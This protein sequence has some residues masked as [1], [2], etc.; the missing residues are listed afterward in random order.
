MTGHPLDEF[1]PTLENGKFVPI[2]KLTEQEDKSTVMIAG[3]LV[4]VE[5]KFTKKESKP[6]AIVTLEDFTGQLEVMIWSEAYTK[7]QS[8]LVQGAVVSITGRLD[9]RE[10]GP[11]LT[12][13]EVKPVKKPTA[14]QPPLVLTL[15]RRATT[16][17]D[18][19]SIRDAILQNPGRR[20]V[21]L[22]FVG[23]GD[24]PVRLLPSDDFR[25]SPAAEAMLARWVVL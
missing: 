16:E 14:K 18:L 9:L 17:E 11:R 19:L 23:E 21:E 8:L 6:F 10:E 25:V 20:N 15:D 12:A 3:A 4:I 2:G 22:R 1:R 5:K 24:T 13:N 7:A